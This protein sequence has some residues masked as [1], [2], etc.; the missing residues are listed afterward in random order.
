MLLFVTAVLCM[1]VAIRPVSD[2]VTTPVATGPFLNRT[3]DGLTCRSR[4]P[5]ACMM[6]GRVLTAL[7]KPVVVPSFELFA[8]S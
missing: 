4:M 6:N 2:F 8:A 5:C 7:R 3:A 1:F